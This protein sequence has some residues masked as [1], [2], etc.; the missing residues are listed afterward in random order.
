MLAEVMP[1]GHRRNRLRSAFP[2]IAI[3]LSDII[4][5]KETTALRATILH[6]VDALGLMNIE[7][8]PRER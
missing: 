3:L 6:V 7:G 4:V 1:L 8:L 5:A 2:M